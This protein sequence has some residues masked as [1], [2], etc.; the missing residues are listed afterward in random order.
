MTHDI[1]WATGVFEG[2]GYI[3]LHPKYKSVRLGMTQSD[4]DIL[5]RIQ[6]IFG[7]TISPK[8]Y[9]AKPKH[10]KPTWQW[11]LGTAVEVTTVLLQMLPLLGDRRACKALDALDHLDGVS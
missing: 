3:V 10:Y 7:G 9:R 11:R 6:K 5:L 1:A 4:L 2:E 8:N